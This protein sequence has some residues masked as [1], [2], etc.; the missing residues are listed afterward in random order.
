MTKLTPEERIA[1]IEQLAETVAKLESQ[2]PISILQWIKLF[3]QKR[4]LERKL[5]KD[6]RS[7]E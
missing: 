3:R 5:A 4:K 1:V 6:E 7:N 2:E